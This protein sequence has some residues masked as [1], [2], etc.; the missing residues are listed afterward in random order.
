ML[1]LCSNWVKTLTTTPKGALP[2]L[3]VFL[4][5]VVS[6]CTLLLASPGC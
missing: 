3:L 1:V 6:R 5:F 2:K 4:Q